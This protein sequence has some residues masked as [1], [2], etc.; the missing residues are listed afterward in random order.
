MNDRV[1]TN[2]EELVE[3]LM[4][5]DRISGNGDTTVCPVCPVKSDCKGTCVMTWIEYL[6]LEL[7]LKEN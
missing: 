4:L 1:K 5:V 7:D 6:G 2:K 3:L